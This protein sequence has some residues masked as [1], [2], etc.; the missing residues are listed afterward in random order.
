MPH[1]KTES[2][3]IG[4]VVVAYNAQSTLLETLDRIPVGFRPSIEEV[5]I[6]DDASGDLTFEYGQQWAARDD[7][8]STTVIKHTKNLGYGGNQKAA[9]LL[10]IEQGLDLVVLLHADGQYAPESLVDIVAPF[11]TT[12]CAAV[13][14]SRMM[15]KGAAKNG[16]MPFYKRIGNKVLTRFEN[17]VLGTDLTEFHSGYRAYRTSALREIPFEANSDGFDFDTQ[18]IAQVIHAGGRIVEVPIPTYY[19]DEI[20]YVNG[21]KY[22]KDVVRDVIEYRLAVQ[23]FGTSEW[24]PT[25]DEY[26]FKEG[27]GSSHSLI[28]EMMAGLAPSKVLD[29]G[30]SAGLLAEQIRAAGH[31]VVGVDAIELPEVRDRTDAFFVADLEKPL[32]PEIGTGFDVVIAGDI[33]EHLARPGDALREMRRVLRPGGQLILSVPNFGHWYPRFRVTFG[34]FGYD[35]RGVLDNTHLRF[36]TRSTLRRTVRRAGFDVLQEASTGLPLGTIGAS[37]GLAGVLRKIDAALVRLRPTLF[38]Y[39]N[40]LRLTPHAEDVLTAAI[41]LREPNVLSRAIGA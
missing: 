30:C 10:A 40:V 18:I 27:D 41:T 21:L 20:C 36:F 4:I 3:R 28:L 39:Q 8:P 25:P 11:Y 17:T 14:G 22:A 23:G 7:T 16:G 13:F 1:S 34:L 12:D 37:G 35:R 19:G 2:L 9:Y 29:L 33:I 6:C 32:A 38:G 26:A 5:I 24:V 15:D 31:T